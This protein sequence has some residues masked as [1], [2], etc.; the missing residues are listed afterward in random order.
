MRN[1]KLQVFLITITFLSLIVLLAIQISWILKAADI[2][3][4]QFNQSVK[5]A[6]N[7]IVDKVSQDDSICKEVADCI[8]KGGT[9][10]CYNSMYRQVEWSRLD[11]IVQCALKQ[12]NIN[13]TYELD[14]VDPRK[15]QD[16]RTCKQT[17]FSNN[18]QNLLLQNVEL[19]IKFPEKREFIAAQVGAIFISS[20]LLIILVSISFLLILKFYKR[21]KMLYRNTR[22]FINNIT[23]EFKTPITN[24]ALANSMMSKDSKVASDQKLNHYASIIRVEQKKLKNRVEGLLDI[25]RI[26][27]GNKTVCE[28][29]DICNI[30][31]CTADSYKV[32]VNELNGSI[33]YQK[34]SDKCT[35]HADK[36]QLQIVISNLIDNAIK[37]CSKE[38]QIVLKTYHKSDNVIFEIEDNGIGIKHEHLSQIFEKYY[39]I[40]T[41]DI[42]NVKGFGIG[43][44]TVKTI[45]ES[46]D[47][48]IDVQSKPGK[49]STFIIKLPFC[50]P[51]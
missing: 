16:F 51:V 11:S 41:G 3:E 35:V 1:N 19:K 10:S 29:I 7:L 4:K 47:G 42:H 8:G 39:R 25:A 48:K 50:S 40:P 17:Y 28:T 37:Y 33:E 14:I 32:Q 18:L 44:S 30:I 22:D 6:I 49:G 13:T 27:N 34:L 15:D 38:P 5:L 20:V 45:I 21:E 43:L 31:R 36:E 24:I 26:E 2:Q 9:T 12:Y 46:L 23:H